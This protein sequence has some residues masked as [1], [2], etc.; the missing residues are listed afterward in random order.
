MYK[1]LILTFTLAAGLSVLPNAFAAPPPAPGK[2]RTTTQAPPPKPNTTGTNKHSE[3]SIDVLVA[4]KARPQPAPPSKPNTT[5]PQNH[6]EDSIDVFAVDMTTAPEPKY[7]RPGRPPPKGRYGEDSATVLAWKQTPLRPGAPRPKGRHSEDSI[8]VLAVDFT[9]APE[10]KYKRPGRPPPKGKYG[11]DR[12]DVL[13]FKARPQPAPP[14]KPNTTK[15]PV[16]SED[17]ATVLAATAPPKQVTPPGGVRK[18]NIA[19][20]GPKHSEDSA[21]VLAWKIP[22]P[23]RRPIKHG[24][25]STIV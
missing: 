25:D 15:T 11:E 23:P 3:D 2:Q 6:G 22:P 21:T 18:Q 19:P 5:R 14:S 13:A 7:K 9:T 17:S 16:H 1:K 24:L 4:I 12:I 20:G 10:P 8:D